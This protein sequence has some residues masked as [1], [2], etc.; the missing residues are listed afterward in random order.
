MTTFRG[1]A[2]LKAGVYV[3]TTLAGAIAASGT[4][5]RIVV[6]TCKGYGLRNPLGYFESLGPQ[7]GILAPSLLIGGILAFLGTR[8]LFRSLEALASDASA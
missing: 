4:V 8:R 2:I 7:V 6:Y 3:T 1:Y 5:A